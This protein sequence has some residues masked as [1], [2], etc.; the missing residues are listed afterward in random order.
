[1]QGHFILGDECM[2]RNVI[3]DCDPGIDDSLALML[4]LSNPSI[5]V[6]AITIVAGNTP[7]DL[8]FENCKRILK[9]MNRLD[10]PIY[11]GATAPLKKT[12][13]DA[14]DTHGKDGLGESFLPAVDGYKQNQS[15]VEYLKTYLRKT[16]CSIIALG[17]LTNI[18]QFIQEDPEGFRY[19]QKFVSMGGTY[20]AHGN[21]SPVAE[22]NYWED[23]EAADIVFEHASNI[24]KKIHM[25]GLDVTRKIV[26]TPNLLTYMERLNP[27][28]G[29][30]IRQITKF[31]MEFHWNWE[32]IIGCVINDPL[33]V[34]YF[35]D[36]S[37]CN[38]FE[39]Y[40]RVQ[41]HGLAQ[42]QSIVDDHNYYRKGANAIV[43]NQVNNKKFFEL[44]FSNILNIPTTQ[45]DLLHSLCTQGDEYEI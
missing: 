21:C 32:H 28:Q 27:T 16:P 29:K 11:I 34:A 39:S 9:H 33:A 6:K 10:I 19:V 8:G 41:D 38:G 5:C 15:A 43:L 44:F 17:P 37:I 7:A 42:G 45:L 13:V 1:M 4:A 40:V 36:P 2:I 22:Y 26:L 25:I 35:I 30:F 31:Y 24:H 3:I 18:A 14:L 12:F 23:P 20:K